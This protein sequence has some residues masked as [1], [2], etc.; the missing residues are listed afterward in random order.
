M[1]IDHYE[2]Y[3]F[4]Y[5]NRY[6]TI[7]SYQNVL[8]T[9]TDFLKAIDYYEGAIRYYNSM[10]TIHALSKAGTYWFCQIAVDY[11]TKIIY[12]INSD[13]YDWDERT[14]N[15]NEAALIQ[16]CLQNEAYYSTMSYYNFCY[17]VCA[18][19]EILKIKPEFAMLYQDEK[20]WI[21]LMPFRTKRA[22]KEFVTL[23]SH[24]NLLD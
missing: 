2:L 16:R 23:N 21:D 14:D 7:C 20:G 3:E 10:T 17:L 15:L 22:M 24:F 19:I 9:I 8:E 13:V 4:N 1:R 11:E 18:W 12:I 6:F 5:K